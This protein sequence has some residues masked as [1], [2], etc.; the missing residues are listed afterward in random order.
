MPLRTR[1]PMLLSEVKPVRGGKTPARTSLPA[2]IAQ[3]RQFLRFLERRVSS[4]AVAEDILQNAYLRALEHQ[5][6]LHSGE[7][8]TAWFYRI[9]RNA[10]IDF[11]R[12]RSVEDRA[13]AQWAGE[14]ETEVP[15]SDPLQD[16]V[17]RC[18]AKVLP[19]L[20]P[21]YAE[22]LRQV[23]LDEQSLTEF[24]ARHGITKANATVRVH[25]ARKALKQRLIDTCGACAIHKCLHCNCI[26]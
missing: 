25:R 6:E 4:A 21:S 23:D 5:G 11:Y 19:M 9:L 10:V 14:L 2:L 7:S 13:L 15:P 17:C 3:R 8:S 26:G 1:L 16:I 18:V 20:T 22:I 24:A 12:H